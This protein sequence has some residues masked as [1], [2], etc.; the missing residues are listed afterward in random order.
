LRTELSTERIEVEVPDGSVDFRHLNLSRPGPRCRQNLLERLRHPTASGTRA[1]D[2]RISAT[3]QFHRLAPLKR[4][5]T[6]LNTDS[7]NETCV[8]LATSSIASECR[9]GL[10]RERA[11]LKMN[12]HDAIAL[13]AI[14][15]DEPEL[16]AAFF[17]VAHRRDFAIAGQDCN[18]TVISNL[19]IRQLY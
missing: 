13:L 14:D 1:L 17:P 2:A 18:R 3:I 19:F 16:G 15:S 5:R 8:V 7:R 11:T 10:R 6:A 12:E 4:M 9:R